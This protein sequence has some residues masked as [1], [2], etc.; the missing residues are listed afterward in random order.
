MKSFL[1]CFFNMPY[2]HLNQHLGFTLMATE[3]KRSPAKFSGI[4]R[5]QNFQSIEKHLGGH[6]VGRWHHPELM[7]KSVEIPKQCGMILKK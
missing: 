1:G 6:G 5:K 2:Y 4:Y 3:R 7:K